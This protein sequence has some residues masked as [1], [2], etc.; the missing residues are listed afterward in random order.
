M[1]T[2]IQ[3]RALGLLPLRDLPNKEGFVFIGVLKDGSEATCN[4]TLDENGWHRVAG[5]ATYNQLIG[6]RH[7]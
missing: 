7:L 4:V 1:Y 2:D 5:S 3:L 6:W